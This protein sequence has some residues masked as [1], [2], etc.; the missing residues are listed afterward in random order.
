MKKLILIV[1]TMIYL[2]GCS[3]SAAAVTVN[4]VATQQIETIKAPTLIEVLKIH[5]NTSKMKAVIKHLESRVHKTYYVFSGAS[6]SG[7]DCSGL[8]VWAY[9]QFGL[10]LPHSATA[11]AHL[12]TRV[13]A[14]KVG[15]I[16]TFGYGS[17][18]FDH[19]A[20]YIGN[21]KVINANKFY[22]TTVIEPL[23]NFS[24]YD[25]IRFIRVVT[26]E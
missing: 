3:S 14:P 8:V 5:E 2:A 1:S 23:S 20:I 11:Q 16:V 18:Y 12:G 26:T 4:T 19:A 17:Y 6:P 10:N 7:W 22:G 25:N 9:Q 13:K 24:Y 21:G 15:D